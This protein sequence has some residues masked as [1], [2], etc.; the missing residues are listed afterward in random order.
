M[1]SLT[2]R[3]KGGWFH[4]RLRGSGSF[5]L[6]LQHPEGCFPSSSSLR[7]YKKVTVAPA[8]TSALQVEKEEQGVPVVAQQLTNPT[9]NHEVAGSIPGRA[10]WVEWVGDPALP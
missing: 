3:P 10:Q 1:F 4:K 9:R 6:S 5:C 2:L 7:A 8:I